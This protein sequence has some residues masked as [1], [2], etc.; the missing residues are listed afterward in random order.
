MM[1]KNEHNYVYSKASTSCQCLKRL[2]FTFYR[3][4]Y[5]FF[6][7]SLCSWSLKKVGHTLKS[8]IKITTSGKQNCL[9]FF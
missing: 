9:M 5:A 6:D 2:N 8:N 3:K 4:N 7:L 1:C